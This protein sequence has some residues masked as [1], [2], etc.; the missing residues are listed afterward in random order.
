MSPTHITVCICTFRRPE[1]LGR[2]LE[3]LRDLC[4]QGRFVY[5]IVVADNDSAES[6]RKTAERF[7][8]SDTVPTVY[9][10]EP[11]QNI[12]LARNRAVANAGGDFVAFIDDDEF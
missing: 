4:T 6:G 1:L 12:A 2:L 7:A 5:S 10:V 8:A 9:C 11:V 3:E